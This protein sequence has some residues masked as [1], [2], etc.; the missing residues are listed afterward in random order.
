MN[1]HE[2]RQ[3][4]D[5][6]HDSEGECGLHFQINEHLAVCPACAEWFGQQSRLESLLAEKLAAPPTPA[7]WGPV[8][9][10]TGLKPRPARHWFW[11]S[12]VAASAAAVL[13]LVWQWHRATPP[14]ADLAE[15]SAQ[16]HRRLVEGRE[17]APFRSESDVEV[18]RYLR[19]QVSFPVRCPPR[20]DAG[21]AVRGAGVC[22]LARQPAAYLAG[23]VDSTPVSI[24]V[25]PRDNLDAFP[26]Q[27]QALAREA[28][29][30]CREGDYQMVLGVIDR[31]AVVVVGRT[32]PENLERVLNAYGSYPDDD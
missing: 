10:R 15:L 26:P 6:Y 20:K 11:L 1:C 31:N 19:R 32:S 27:S 7:L 22:Q 24:F 5:L 28:R 25:L 16:W 2:A 14:G 30:R 12:A 13:L 29:H 18:E 9:T 21:F 4:W 3:H 23:T 8:L 17:V